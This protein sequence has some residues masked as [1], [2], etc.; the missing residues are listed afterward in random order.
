MTEVLLMTIFDCFRRITVYYLIYEG[1]WST[2]CDAFLSVLGVLQ[3]IIWFKKVTEVLLVTLFCLLGSITVYY[4]NQGVHF[5]SW[6]LKGI[7][8]YTTF[9]ES[10]SWRIKFN[11]GYTTL[12][13]ST[14][15][16]KKWIMNTQHYPICISHM[17]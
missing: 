9:S 16:R 11:K 8:G 1:D 4:L 3:C 6:L 2:S 5:S 15:W 17:D 14:S 7:I 13:D 10:T 12:S